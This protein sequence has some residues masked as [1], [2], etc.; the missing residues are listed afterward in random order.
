MIITI[1]GPV[2]SGKSSTAQALAKELKFY[3][4]YTGLL[5]RAVAYLLQKKLEKE[6]SGEVTIHDFSRAVD[7]LTERQLEFVKDVSYDYGEDGDDSSPY[8]FYGEENITAKLSLASLDQPASIVSANKFV[9]DALLPVQRAVSKRY[10]IVADGRDCGTVV[11]PDADYKFYLT[12]SVDVRVERLMLDKTRG[13]I[14]QDRETIKAEL[15]ERDKRDQE[16][17]VAPLKIPEG[18]IIVDNSELTQEET[19]NKFL[20]SIKVP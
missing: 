1:D 17:E 9:R 14:S 20:R 13:E 12:S 5:Y 16:R 15:E 7:R 8:L 10:D 11:F 3:Y 18:A 6:Q 19:V 2:A 4:L